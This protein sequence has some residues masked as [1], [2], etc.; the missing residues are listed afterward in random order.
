VTWR[1]AYSLL[2]E[3]AD[4]SPQ[5]IRAAA[6]L[7]ISLPFDP[8]PVRS[9][10]TTGVGSSAAAAKLLAHVLSAELG[11][12]A[13]FAHAG[14]F[15]AQPIACETDVLIVFSTG[16]S[17][18]A[19]LALCDPR[20]WRSVI[21]VSAV[22]AGEPGV[23]ADKLAALHAVRDAGGLSIQIPGGT[24]YGTLLRV[25]APLASYVIALRLAAAIGQAAGRP[26]S[27]LAAETICARMQ[28]A[29]AAG[30]ALIGRDDV[31]GGRVAFLASGGYGDLADNLALKIQEGLFLPTPPLWDLIG[32][33]HGPFQEICEQKL[34]LLMLQRQAAPLEHD[35]L[36]RLRSMLDSRCHRLLMLPAELPGPLALFEH[37]ALLNELV[38]QAIEAR[39]IDQG[40]WPG[41]ERDRPLYEVSQAAA[42]AATG[43]SLRPGDAVT[44]PARVFDVQTWPELDA[45]I[46]RGCRTA[47][48]PLGATEQHGP[49]LPLATDSVI[50]AALGERF[51][52]RVGEAV[53]LPVLPIG[54]SSEHADFP[55]T[56][57]LQPDTL[58][59][60]LGDIV[61]SLARQGFGTAVI[62]SAH[63]GNYAT[64]ERALPA[65]RAAAHPMR[66]CAFTDLA[67][68]AAV[69][70]A[71]SAA[72]GIDAQFAGHH[73][74]EFETSILL[75]LRPDLVRRGELA[76]GLLDTGAD[77]QAIFYPSLRT[78]SPSGVVGDP[79]RASAAHGER[80]LAAW[81]DALVDWY[82]REKN[83]P[84]TTGTHRA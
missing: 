81:V 3:R 40:D 44:A 29:A 34:T 68:I 5:L 55:G 24:E 18:N 49:H 19:R 17:P 1:K 64:L 10:V 51:C 76:A 58:R 78:H 37:E 53:C 73:A 15:V 23:D 71:A 33:A 77:P 67:R 31:F 65:L 84:Y 12:P 56:V 39:K 60:A 22:A 25:A 7:E 74:G 72:A 70:H 27:R 45:L 35:L 4:R 83:A 47:V 30:R 20:A 48:L 42:R 21:V 13:R 26:A 82:Q 59:A 80:Y 79:R 43:S 61:A 28:A 6:G 52:R 41:H 63:G 38:L 62:L 54:C 46:I 69:W 16:L 32:F 50:A 75:A 57:S 36:A 9:F 8:R 14:A 66:V 11:L 2:R